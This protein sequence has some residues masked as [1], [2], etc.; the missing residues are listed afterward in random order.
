MKKTNSK[1]AKISFYLVLAMCMAMIGV[2]CWFAYTQTSEEI[3]LQLDSAM[4]SVQNFYSAERTTEAPTAA[5]TEKSS[6]ISG[7]SWEISSYAETDAPIREASA[8]PESAPEEQTTQ[9][10]T[11][12]PV[13]APVQTLRFPVNGE[14]LKPY[15]NGELVKSETTGVWQTHNGIDL[16]CAKGDPVFAMDKGIISDITEDPLWGVCVTVDHQNSVCSRYCGLQTDVEVSVGDP[17]TV[18]TALGAAGNTAD[19]ESAMDC[20]VHFEVTQGERYLDPESYI[21]GE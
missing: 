6:P 17:V 8:S 14:I 1:S 5:P 11:A 12:A 3:T 4:D 13:S 2:S 18:D 9:A 21:Q 10:P 19:V 20:H 7:G 15:S 16:A